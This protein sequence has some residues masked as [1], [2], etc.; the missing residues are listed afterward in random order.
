MDLLRCIN[1][2][3]ADYMMK[4]VHNGVCKPYLNGRLLAKKIMRTGYFW[5]TIEHDCVDFIKKCAK[6]QIYADVIHAL[7]TELH[8]MTARWPYS[9]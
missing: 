9:M 8:S 3:E 6:C 4:E 2:D 1:R 5:L 7:S